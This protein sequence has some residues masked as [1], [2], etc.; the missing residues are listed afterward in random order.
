MNKI[1][2]LILVFI[3]SPLSI[4]GEKQYP[5]ILVT[6]NDKQSILQKIEEQKWAKTIFDDLL[7][8]VNPY[9][10]RHQTDPDWILSRYLLN[11]A[12]GKRYTHAYDN[13]TGHYLVGYS[14]DAPVPTVRVS[15][16]KR[17]PVTE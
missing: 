6:D 17:A 14:G 2:P 9:V 3:L 12:E 13:G 7:S 4:S 1:I 10:E 5:H 8:T 16:H 15:T 11:R